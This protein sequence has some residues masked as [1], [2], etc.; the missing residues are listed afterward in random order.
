[1]YD[2]GTGAIWYYIYAATRAEIEALF[3]KLRILDEEPAWFDE[4]FRRKIPEFHLGSEP[5][6]FLKL[7]RAKEQN[8]N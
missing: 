3:P 7:M 6:S 5:D 8:S 4:D 2:Y 1:V